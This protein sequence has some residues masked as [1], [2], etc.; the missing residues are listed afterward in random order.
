MTK[1]KVELPAP[2]PIAPPPIPDGFT[3]LHQWHDGI[4]GWLQVLEQ[5]DAKGQRQKFDSVNGEPPRPLS[6]KSYV[7]VVRN[8]SM[9]GAHELVGYF[10]PAKSK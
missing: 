7:D 5:L 8:M 2:A 9:N 10:D 6:E 4:G 3:A 1:R